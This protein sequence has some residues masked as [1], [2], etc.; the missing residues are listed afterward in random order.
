MPPRRRAQPRS[1]D[2]AA[3]G[4][5]VEALRREAGLTQEELA[6]RIER[7]SPAVGSVERG[8]ANPTYSSLLGLAG[9]L[10]TELSALIR[11]AEEIRGGREK[12][13]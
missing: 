11:R 5:A 6:S 2:H 4:G 12:G 8:T 9:G 13:D 7:E 3:L 10:G 1:P